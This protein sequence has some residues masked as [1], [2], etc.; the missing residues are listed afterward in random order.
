VLGISLVLGAVLFA[1]LGTPLYERWSTGKND[2]LQLYAGARLVGTPELY[3]IEASKRIHVE[4]TGTWYPSVYWTRLPWYALVLSPLGSLEYQTAYRIWVAFNILT[5]GAW[6]LSFWWLWD[7]LP[8]FAALSLPLMV[9]FTNGQDAGLVTA[10]AGFAVLL[11]RR[12]LDFWAGLLFA[13]C[14]IKFH[15][16]FLLPVVLVMHRRWKV[17]HGALAGACVLVALSI[18]AD[19]WYWPQHFLNV[20]TNPELHPHP[21][22]MPTLYGLLYMMG[23][24]SRGAE[25]LLSLGV[26]AWVAWLS[27]RLPIDVSLGLS[28]AGGVL[29]CHHAYLADTLIVLLALALFAMN[30]VPKLLLGVTMV[31]VLP[32]TALA[33]LGD[34]PGNALMH[35]MLIAILAA[36]SVAP[37]SRST[38]GLKPAAG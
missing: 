16:F 25:V 24:H 7:E 9:N 28:L 27:R 3:D 8:I 2:F 22:R 26:A 23:I 33:I 32:L 38:G 10:F 5:V 1:F 11:M 35:A 19:G 13:L 31:T 30:R 36:G 4:V 18:L 29:V 34:P 21:E 12:N 17:I 37:A 20:V 14:S 6:L 15:L